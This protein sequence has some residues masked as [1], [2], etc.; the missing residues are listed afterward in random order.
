MTLL[1]QLLQLCILCE[2]SAERTLLHSGRSQFGLQRRLFYSTAAYFVWKWIL[3]SCFSTHL[4]WLF[5]LSVAS[6]A[7]TLRCVLPRPLMTSKSYS[8]LTETI[9]HL[10][11]RRLRVICTKIPHGRCSLHL[12]TRYLTTH[13]WWRHGQRVTRLLVCKTTRRVKQPAS[14]SAAVHHHHPWKQKTQPKA[15]RLLLYTLTSNDIF[16]TNIE[17][18]VPLFRDVHR[19]LTHCK[20]YHVSLL[21][22]SLQTSSIIFII[23]WSTAFIW[24]LMK[25]FFDCVENHTENP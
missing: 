6:Y 4:H 19:C 25:T 5:V 20:L 10:L 23:L 14:V 16:V 2:V 24:N 21:M 8:D 12:W 13:R 3:K 18:L 9:A 11:A 15:V 22:L 17:Y 1:P 7:Y